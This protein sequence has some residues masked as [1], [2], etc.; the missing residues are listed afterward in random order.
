MTEI[1]TVPKFAIGQRA[2]LLQTPNGNVLWD[3]VSLIDDATVKAIE[4]LGGISSLAMS[5]PHL[6]GSMVEWSHAFGYAPI[7]IHS[8]NKRWIM[9]PDP[10]IEFWDGDK[11]RLDQGL[12]LH[13]CGGHFTGST[14]L[15]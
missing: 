11:L 14:V 1:V 5:H 9:R 2:L 10:V 3:C 15:H 12:I 7:Y 8:A 6:C 13:R 4:A